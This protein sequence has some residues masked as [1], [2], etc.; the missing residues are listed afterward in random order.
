MN[1]VEYC[2]AFYLAYDVVFSCR[3]CV[4]VLIIIFLE[5]DSSPKN[6]NLLSGFSEKLLHGNHW[7]WCVCVSTFLNEYLNLLTKVLPIEQNLN[8]TNACIAKG[9]NAFISPKFIINI[10][11]L[12]W[13]EL[14]RYN[15]NL[16]IEYRT[17]FTL[18]YF[19]FGVIFCFFFVSSPFRCRL[20]MILTWSIFN[21]KSL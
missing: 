18:L 21:G 8:W 20:P 14:C 17:H 19:N 7:I 9:M 15:N 3:W 10:F 13:T 4:F 5:G 1:L 11:V 6:F 2:M 16:S 12:N